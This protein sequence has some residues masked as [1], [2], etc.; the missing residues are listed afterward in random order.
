MI[1]E[2]S[3]DCQHD[4]C[5][6]REKRSHGMRNRKTLILPIVAVALLP[7]ALPSALADSAVGFPAKPV[8]IVTGPSGAGSDVFARPVAQRLHESWGQPV[9]VENRALGSI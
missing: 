5:S 8:R 9:I 2:I 4:G 6:S 3:R 1:V 7:H